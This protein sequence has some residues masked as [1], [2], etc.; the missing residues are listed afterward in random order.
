MNISKY[1][2][3]KL[4]KNFT[5]VFKDI[6]ELS[7]GKYNNEES[8]KE[9]LRILPKLKK[10]KTFDISNSSYIKIDNIKQ[11]P[12]NIE[13]LVYKDSLSK[14]QTLN[15]KDFKLVSRYLDLVKKDK[16]WVHF[17]DAIVKPSKELKISS[18]YEKELPKDFATVFKNI[19]KLSIGSNNNTESEKEFLSILPKLKKLKTLDILDSYIKLKDI[20]K[21]LPPTLETLEYKDSD[22]NKQTLKGEDFKRVAKYLDLVKSD[23]NCKYFIV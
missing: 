4:P 7:I 9:L 20:I 15:K 23:E 21:Q 3:E 1:N 16:K 11:L 22:F 12:P 18:H 8:E 19:E 2:K 6:E 13:K 17:I 10:L 14:K 5:A